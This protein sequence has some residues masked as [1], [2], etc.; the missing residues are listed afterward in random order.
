MV[1]DLAKEGGCNRSTELLLVACD[2][3]LLEPDPPEL[4]RNAGGPPNRGL[5][6]QLFKTA[7]PTPGGRP[8]EDR[9]ANKC[10]L[11]AAAAATAICDCRAAAANL[12]K[13][14]N[15]IN[16]QNKYIKGPTNGQSYALH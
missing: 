5:E 1:L 16:T 9:V 13:L 4:A 11:L 12:F 6:P 3:V 14:R 2:P 8:P 10:C 7:V 15:A